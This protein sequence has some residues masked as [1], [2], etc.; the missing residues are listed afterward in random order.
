MESARVWYNYP[1]QTESDLEGTLDT[2][3][4]IARVLDDGTTQAQQYQYNVIGKPTQAVDPAGRTTLYTYASN[5]IDLLTVAQQVGPTSNILARYTYNSQ[6]LPL[7]GVD[8]AG[9]TNFF[10]YNTNGQLVAMTNA[11]NNTVFLNY[12]TNG[13]LTNIIAGFLKA[14]NHGALT[15]DALS[16]NSFTYDGYG[17]VRTT[18]D[19]LG[20][21]ITYGYDALDRPTNI[22]YMD[23]TYQ[24][25]VYNYLDPALM[26]DRN[27]H[28]TTM[29]HDQL[30]HLTDLYDAIGR[31]T[32]WTW[33]TCGALESITDPNGNVTAW[34]RDLQNRVTA[35]IF[36]DL[37][38]INYRYETNSSRLLSVTDAKNQTKLYSYY[39]DNNLKQVTY[40]NAVVATA[41]V[42]CSYDTN[43]NRILTMVDGTGTN[44]YSYYAITNGQL[45]AGMVSSVSNSFIGS[46][47][48]YSYD[49][50][51]RGTNRSINSVSEQWTYDALGRVTAFTN[52]LGS[53]SNWFL[54]GTPLT[55][56]NFCPNGKKTILSYLSITN[57]ERLAEIW[58]QKTNSATLSKF[59]YVYDAIGQMT[60]WTRQTDT[61]VTNVHVFTYDPV[62]QLL[63][64]TVHSNTIAGAILQQ[65]AYGYDAGGNRTTEQIGTG[66]AGPVSISQSSY[67]SDNQL[68]SR[69]EAGGQMLFAGY[70]SK[71]ATV[72]LAG[73]AATVNHFTTNFFGYSSVTNGTNVVPVIASDYNGNSATNKYQVLVTNNGV[74]KTITYDLNGNETS[75]VTGTTTNTYQWDAG[76]RLVSITGPTNQSLFTY[77]GLGRRVQII[78]LTN[79][80][81][82]STNK[83]LW[84][85]LDLC[86]QRNN[87]GGTVTRRFFKQG[88]QISG[89]NYFYTRDH[90]GSVREMVDGGGT[91]QARYDYDPYGRR[92][93]LSG[94]LD[95]DF[96]YAGDYYHAISGLCLA[97]LRPYD[98]DL[99]RWLNRDPIGERGGVNLYEYVLNNTLNWLDPFGTCGSEV[100]REGK[101]NWKLFGQSAVGFV[102]GFGGMLVGI[103]GAGTGVG[104]AVAIAS[105]YYAGASFGNMWNALNGDD[106]G[107][108]GPIQAYYDLYAL[109]E[110]YDFDQMDKT[111]QIGDLLFALMTADE[112][113]SL[114]AYLDTFLTSADAFTEARKALNEA[115]EGSGEGGGMAGPC[116]GFSGCSICGQNTP[117]LY[118]TR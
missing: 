9:Q 29:V 78:E 19:P 16:T 49:A 14:N 80:V 41:T 67:N 40:S 13:Y 11:L 105:A 91:I 32:Q 59:D 51:G 10:G 85:G 104:V 68:T 39:V 118:T 90:L 34:A 117:S 50:L 69:T 71:Q 66:A 17:R 84:C 26:R 76:D 48:N 60:N 72:M 5:N 88:E 102:V 103:A 108:A 21:V 70:L 65:Y 79:G 42:T 97:F 36:S 61:T 3:T 115:N 95:A 22:T 82:M 110:N 56:T 46:L 38:Q 15:N 28:W 74:A 81:S 112:D 93:K 96:G 2:P 87:T 111:G 4:I 89:T 12:N 106:P 64:D 23:G 100:S 58:N 24:Q 101:V 45:G 31:H 77:D 6:H 8:P 86:E 33:C 57:D 25:I 20:R 94:N 83:Y 43:Y 92:T 62:N 44:S 37:T 7:T 99:G 109:A 47:I 27:G 113:P 107:P 1:G 54:G 30:R 18:T 98:S 52:A 35:K 114:L 75:V 73:T 53:F 63:S 55:T 116:P